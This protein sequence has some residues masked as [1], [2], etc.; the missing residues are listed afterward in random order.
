MQNFRRYRVGSDIHHKLYITFTNHYDLLQVVECDGTNQ[1]F[2]QWLSSASL[3][4][5]IQNLYIAAVF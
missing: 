3:E 4:V 1:V 2:S 5:V